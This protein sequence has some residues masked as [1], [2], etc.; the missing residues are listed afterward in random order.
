M[1]DRFWRIIDH[2]VIGALAALAIYAAFA[3]LGSP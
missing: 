2:C 1:S 3:R